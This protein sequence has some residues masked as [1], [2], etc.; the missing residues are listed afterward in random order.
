MLYLP[1]IA[2]TLL[3][4]VAGHGALTEVKGLNGVV[5]TAL[6]I[7]DT[8]RTGAGARPFQ[9][10]TSVIRDRDIS[11]GATSACGKTKESGA[12]DMMAMTD[13]VASKNGGKLP[14]V[15]AGETID[16]TIH[17]INQ[18]GAGP[19]NCDIS[20]DGATFVRM[21]VTKNVPGAASL[22]LAT[23]KDFPLV[24]RV[25][26][27]M[28]SC[29]GGSNGA[30]CIIR[31]RNGAAAGPFG[32]CA[33]VM[34]EEATATVTVPSVEAKRS[35]MDD[36]IAEAEEEEDDQFGKRDLRFTNRVTNRKL[37]DAKLDTRKESV[38][39]VEDDEYLQ[40]RGSNG[41][42]DEFVEQRDIVVVDDEYV[43]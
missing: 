26:E 24:V 42:E 31:C 4:L 13:A 28:T 38:I 17:Q 40:K 7:T 10:D 21:E 35:L 43:P 27:S 23:A 32:G 3:T 14:T 16:M 8:P 9:R 1:L 33:P 20:S 15:R 19:Y 6:A 36:M 29:G 41:G 2:A 39:I 37:A 11:S 30:T 34:M 18:D 22:S 12:F 25:P 5:G